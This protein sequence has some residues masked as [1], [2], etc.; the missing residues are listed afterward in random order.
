MK[1]FKIIP[2]V[3]YGHGCAI[4]AANSEEE[5][6]KLYIEASEF[7]KFL[8]DDLNCSIH[9]IEHL[10]YTGIDVVLVDTLFEE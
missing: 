10:T 4:I 1:V 8:F 9:E 6:K 3:C 2:N 5:A 7:N